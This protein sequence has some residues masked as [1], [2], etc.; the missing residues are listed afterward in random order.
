MINTL[1]VKKVF[2]ACSVSSGCTTVSSPF[3]G[4][5]NLPNILHMIY[6]VFLFIVGLV[7]F[8]LIVVSGIRIISSG[9]NREKI[10]SAQKTLVSAI[11]G[12]VIILLA[13]VILGL[14]GSIIPGGQN[15]GL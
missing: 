7:F 10:A 15:F 2:A 5:L 4:G 6:I 1:L 12:L 9:G 14:L 13:S 3:G 11:I 8:I